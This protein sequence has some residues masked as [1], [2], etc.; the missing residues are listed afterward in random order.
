[1]SNEMISLELTARQFYHSKF[2]TYHNWEHISYVLSQYKE[3]FKKEPS[4][5]EFAA[6][7]FHDCV[8]VPGSAPGVNETLSAITACK[9]VKFSN[10]KDID[11]ALLEKIILATKV[12]NYLDP[13]FYDEDCNRVLDADVASLAVP[14]DVFL[15]NNANIIFENH[16]PIRFGY[17]MDICSYASVEFMIK[18]SSRLFIYRT[19]E[20]RELLEEKARSNIDRFKRNPRDIND[21]LMKS[22][23][24][25]Q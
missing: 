3:I 20:A 11:V 6:I 2:N 14:Y 1:M 24:F 13:G 9:V 8:Y 23:D 21:Y 5:T 16:G 10:F 17:E 15:Q 19:R 25:V 22:L 4:K 7:L 18:I 12:Q